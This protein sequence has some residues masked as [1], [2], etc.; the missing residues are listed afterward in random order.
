MRKNAA[1][2]SFEELRLIRGMSDD[3]WATFVDPDPNNPDKRVL[4]VWGSRKQKVNVTSAN[5]QLLLTLTCSEQFVDI[6]TTPL[7]ADVNQQTAFLTVASLV[8]SMTGGILFPTPKD[9]VDA[10][11]QKTGNSLG[12]MLGQQFKAM[13]VE[14]VKFKPNATKSLGNRTNFLSIYADGIVPGNKRET[15]VRVHAVLDLTGATKI[16]DTKPGDDP[17]NDPNKSNPNQ[18]GAPPTPESYE[19]QVRSNPAGTIIYYRIE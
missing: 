2:D 1:F 19:T 14:P 16:T 5:A 13:G 3:F 18:T 4:T 7:C 11:T 17:P 6:A 8:Q 10:M 12:A 9:F 15:R